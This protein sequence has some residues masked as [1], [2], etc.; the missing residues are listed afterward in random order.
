MLTTMTEKR[1]YFVGEASIKMV[2][3][4]R[5]KELTKLLMQKQKRR[6]MKMR[7]RL[8]NIQM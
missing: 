1:I 7:F 6:Y 8:Q 5:P 3:Q 2:K 4:S